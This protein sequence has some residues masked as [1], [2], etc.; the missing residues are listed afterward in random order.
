MLLLLGCNKQ[1]LFDGYLLVSL[2]ILC[3]V[4]NHI[5]VIGFSITLFISYCRFMYLAIV[6]RKIR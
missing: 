2:Y 4:L 6:F 3:N 1:V 5:N